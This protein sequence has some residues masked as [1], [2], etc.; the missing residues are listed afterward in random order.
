MSGGKRLL[1]ASEAPGSGLG[2]FAVD[3]ANALEAR[4]CVVT[5]IA[6]PQPYAIKVS[7]V[8]TLPLPEGKRRIDKIIALGRSS[9][10]VAGHVLRK[11]GPHRP[12]LMV[13]LQ[14]TLPVSLAPLIAAKLAR[15]RSIL[16]L[17]DFY[18]HT[19]RFPARLQGLERW[20][21]RWAYRRFD[22]IV[23]NNDEQSRRLIN[24]AHVAQDRVRTLFHGAFVVDGVE[25][26]DDG[27]HG[28]RLLVFGSLRPNKQVLESI[29]AVTKLQ[30]QGLDVELRIAGAPRREDVAYWRACVAQIPQPSAS[31]DIQARFIDDAELPQLLSGIDAMLCPYVEFDSQ[32]GVAVVAVSNAIPIIATANVTVGG[33]DLDRQPWPGVAMPADSAAIMRAIGDFATVPRSERRQQALQLQSRFLAASGW[34]RLA[35]LYLEAMSQR[36]IGG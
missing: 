3:L 13:H 11:A 21:Y 30:E 15:A 34:Q 27:Q 33:V 5:L 24:E 22:L 9:L 32:S 36:S 20:L 25:P 23:T 29:R 6:P 7:E 14:P 12:L 35:E 31:F 1:V 17:H 16:S 26:P 10:I 19:L 4:G 2:R 18:P 28:L 8:E